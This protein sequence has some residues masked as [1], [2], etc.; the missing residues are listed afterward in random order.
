[1]MKYLFFILLLL[2]VGCGLPY[3]KKVKLTEDDLLWI[4]HFKA[5]DTIYYLSNQNLIDTV[6]VKDVQIYNPKNTFIFDTEGENWLEG[7]NEFY[8]FA[9]VDL[10]LIH[11]TDTFLIRFEIERI[12]KLGALRSSCN[13]CEWCWI[14]KKI[15][16]NAINIQGQCFKNC[17]SMDIK[18]MERNKGDQP[19]IG[20]KSVIWDKEKGLIQYSL[21]NGISYTIISAHKQY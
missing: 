7:D 11:F 8:G 2:P 19:H 9:T 12:A 4:N 18:K 13:F 21:L 20:L 10:S 14:N 3:C 16:V 5:N 1:M 17:I 15:H 6:I